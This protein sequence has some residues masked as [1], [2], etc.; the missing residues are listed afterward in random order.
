MKAERTIWALLGDKLGD[1]AQAMELASRLHARLGFEV[2]EKLLTYN[3]EYKTPNIQLGATLKSVLPERRRCLEQS[4]APSV[5][6]FTG[7][8][9]VPPARWIAEHAADPPVLIAIGKPQAPYHWFDLI[10]TTRQYRLVG[11]FPNIIVNDFTLNRGKPPVAGQASSGHA[12]FDSSEKVAAVLLGG[13][14]SGF[15]FGVAEADGIVETLHRF[16]EDQPDYSLVVVASRKTPEKA[17]QRIAEAS[18]DFAVAFS[19]DDTSK[20][21][22]SEILHRSRAFFVTEDSASM[23]TEVLA[24]EMP[25]FL[26]ALAKKKNE[27][28]RTLASIWREKRH[29]LAITLGRENSK[30]E[31]RLFTKALERKGWLTSYRSG[32][33]IPDPGPTTRKLEHEMANVVRRIEKI[34][35]RKSRV[36]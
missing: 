15:R 29:A 10:I 2:V 7:R 3:D 26:L 28:P 36:S 27:K 24:T 30:R 16:H 22:Y 13:Q 19:W 25:V 33:S 17:L 9:A 34:V 21:A 5:V 12:V 14:R 18:R 20:P 6:I 35:Q 1:N 8:R 31:V 32:A 23:I 4:P 11:V